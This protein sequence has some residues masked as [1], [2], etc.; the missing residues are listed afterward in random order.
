MRRGP[1]PGSASGRPVRVRARPRR[2]RARR[3][4]RL[5]RARAGRGTR[6]S[7]GRAACCTS[8]RTRA[9]AVDRDQQRPALPV[10]DD[11]VDLQARRADEARQSSDGI[12]PRISR[13]CL[14]RRSTSTSASLELDRLVRAP[15]RRAL[16]RRTRTRRSPGASTAKQTS[17]SRRQQ[18][19]TVG[20]PTRDVRRSR[21]R[22]QCP[23]SRWTT[24]EAGPASSRSAPV[25]R[26]LA[27][28]PSSSGSANVSNVPCSTDSPRTERGLLHRASTVGTQ[29][30]SRSAYRSGPVSGRSPSA[31]TAARIASSGAGCP[32]QRSTWSAAW[33]TSIPIPETA[34]APAARARRARSGVSSGWYTRSTT[35]ARARAPRRR[36]TGRRS[37]VPSRAASRSRR[38]RR[39]PR[40]RPARPRRSPR[41][42]ASAAAACAAAAGLRAAT[43]T[44]APGARRAKRDGARRAARAE[45]QHRAP[46]RIHV[47]VRERPHRSPAPSVESPA[48]RPSGSTVTVLTLR[49]A[50]ASSVESSS[51]RVPRSPSCGAWSPRSRAGRARAPRRPRAGVPPSGTSNATSTQSRPSAR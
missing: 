21:P 39:S 45:H 1:G 8:S 14:S 50:A 19:R 20:D 30:L 2:V 34:V 38:C 15:G 22:R 5:R 6:R 31:T 7:R 33:C 47:G 35:T 25:F 10:D 40:P 48:I 43:A 23:S 16:R 51:Q 28:S 26:A 4:R 18:R 37:P 44:C 9:P 12:T 32:L 11:L 13:H 29:C 41:R 36:S 42:P 27:S 46:G 17:T 3:P 49:S 24:P